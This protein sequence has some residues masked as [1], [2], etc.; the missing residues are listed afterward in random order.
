MPKRGKGIPLSKFIEQGDFKTI[1]EV[2]KATCWNMTGKVKNMM[3]NFDERDELTKQ[4]DEYEKKLNAT[5][6][7]IKKLKNEINYLES[8]MIQLKERKSYY[9]S[10]YIETDKL[11]AKLYTI[12]RDLSTRTD[13]TGS[14]NEILYNI[15]EYHQSI[16][17]NKIDTIISESSLHKNENEK[18]EN[19]CN[20]C[21]VSKPN[22]LLK[23][24]ETY[25]HKFCIE[26]IQ[27]NDKVRKT[28]PMCRS[29]Y[30]DIIRIV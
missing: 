25:G 9:E 22:V 19:T 8:R 1:N 4:K 20:I 11:V 15:N 7:S 12:I 16:I 18:Q 21:Y 30:S 6:S 5:Y 13:R 3:D 26:C 14:T 28:C 29:E 10:K 23:C 24:H 27:E 2:D 17:S